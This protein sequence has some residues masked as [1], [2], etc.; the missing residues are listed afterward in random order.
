MIAHTSGLDIDFLSPLKEGEEVNS[1]EGT[2]A[3]YLNGLSGTD[4]MGKRYFAT[5]RYHNSLDVMISERL[6]KLGLHTYFVGNARDNYELLNESG[7]GL[8]CMSNISLTPSPS[9]STCATK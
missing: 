4:R 2:M 5:Q 9:P 3:G 1:S 8:R 7:G 6:S